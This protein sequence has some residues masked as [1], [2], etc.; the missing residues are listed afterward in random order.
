MKPLDWVVM[1]GWL[2]FI[3]SYGLWRGRK[4]DSVNEFLLAGKTMPWYAM[5][6]S[7]MAT[8]PAP[9]PSSPQ[10]GNPM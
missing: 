7:I 3:V 8:R 6:L 4:S 10:P 1:A 5:G 9:S 2:A